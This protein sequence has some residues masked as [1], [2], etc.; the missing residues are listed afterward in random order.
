MA[1]P[2]ECDPAEVA[3]SAV[4]L[5]RAVDLVRARGAK[6]QLCVVR[7]GRVVL[8]RSFSCEPDDLFW[9]FSASKPFVALVIHRLVERG[10]LRLDDAVA[11]HWPGFAAHGK[12]DVTIRD[13][14]RH[15]SGLTTAGS[16]AGDALSMM[17]WD[18]MVRRIERV[19]IR[20]PSSPPAYS[21]IMYGFVLGEVAQ[22]V[23]GRPIRDLVQDI[24]DAIGA[25]DTFLGLPAAHRDRAVPVRVASPAAPLVRAVVNRRATRAAVIPSAGIST[26]ARDLAGLYVSLL[27]AGAARLVSPATLAEALVPTSDG[28]VDATMGVSIRWSQGFQLGG[29]R[30]RV[31]PMGAG[32]NPRAFGHNGSNCCIGWADPDRNVAYAYLTDQLGPRAAC[33]RHHAE[34]ADAILS[35]CAE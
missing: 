21:P 4:R 16:A 12:A 24:L 31:G 29:L 34:V 9:I 26:T 5:A 3:M 25:Q 17:D 11:R 7:D 23:T 30:D 18:R 32:S 22:R 33:V 19:G 8:D 13:V 20:R 1:A 6:A 14:L 10:Q 15:R 27:G 28:E 35:A 2:V